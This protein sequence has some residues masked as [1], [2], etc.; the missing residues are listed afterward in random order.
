MAAV[1]PE[2]YIKKIIIKYYL[3]AVIIEL[4]VFIKTKFIIFID[5]FYTPT[6]SKEDIKIKD[7]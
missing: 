2:L 7:A 5:I 1:I 3:T 6:K 4:R